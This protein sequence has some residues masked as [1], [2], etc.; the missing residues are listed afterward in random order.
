[1]KKKFSLI[2]LAL[3]LVLVLATGLVACDPETPTPDGDGNN[4]PAGPTTYTI[5][6]D[7]QDGSE[8]TTQQVIEGGTVVFP[9]LESNS[10]MTFRGWFKNADGTGAWLKT[11]TV[12]ESITL[13]ACWNQLMAK[14][15]FNY[16]YTGAP[17][18]VSEQRPLGKAIELPED[19]T[20][21]YWVFDGWYFDAEA[22]DAYDGTAVL[23][24]TTKLYAGWK[25]DPTHQHDFDTETVAPTC[26]EDGY[27]KHTCVCTTTY[28]DNIVP[29]IGHSFTFS[30]TDYMGMVYCNNGCNYAER[31]ESLR[32]YEDDFVYTFDSAKE[33][34]I[35]DRYQSMLDILANADRYDQALHSY[36]KTSEFYT[37][38]QEFE[39]IF[40][41]FY[42][43]LMYLIEQYQYAYVFYCVD[44]SVSNTSAY[45]KITEYRTDAVSDFYALYRLIYE[46]CFREYFFDM[47]EGGWTEEDIQMALN[48]SDSYGSEDYAEI[49][50]RLGEIEVEFREISDPSTGLQT[51]KLY[52][53]F[54]ELNN[55][56]ATLA[57]YDNYIEY[58]YENVYNREYSPEDTAVMRNYVK[59]HLVDVYSAIYQGYRSSNS[60]L[61][62]DADSKAIFNALSYDSIFDSKIVTDMVQ[63][64]F[65]KMNS[66][67][68][69]AG[70]TAI[71]F[72][73]HANELFKNGNYYTGQYEGAY[74]YWIG[75]Q[76]TSILY[77]GPGSYS[78]A[79]TFVH[80]FG[81]YYNNI[82]NPGISFSYD[83]DETHS[84]GNE[85]MFLAFLKD[86]YLSNVAI[87]Q[88]YNKIYFE[89]LFNIFN[90]IMLATAVDEF[91]YCVYTGKDLDGNDKTYGVRDYDKLFREIMKEY[92]IDGILVDYYWRYVV[93]EA[94][95]YYISYAM[96][97]LPCVELLTVANTD[98]FEAAQAKYFKFFTFTDDPDNVEIDEMGDKVVK[99]GYA[100]TL[101]YVGL[102]SIFEEGLY[103]TLKDY[104]VEETEN[105]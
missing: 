16:N 98:G 33:K 29:A 13:Y 84:Q 99:I 59:S 24:G 6:L 4:P 87:E 76:D 79:F 50:K 52:G 70:D 63:A 68:G 17:K 8:P 102:H 91:E 65:E 97:A 80:E 30:D 18:Q 58:A 44:D 37:Q 36:D 51:P 73:H 1:M 85:M 72:H 61:I 9:E 5:T 40:N 27:D 77:F 82:Y 47:N 28:N 10:Y 93:I 105:E 69:V 81:H 14:V 23:T 66:A 46:T 38:N 94:P 78:G 104:F 19:P 48:M 21:E 86:S 34:E 62:T 74:S 35:N 31:K 101:K 32:I 45:E 42:D 55:Q 15:T 22:T 7:L 41:A 43:D 100:D 56:I 20:R 26:T 88:I 90:T 3:L 96:S 103:T 75:A 67:A 95:C 54:V 89:N 92:G 71:D 64:Y 12:T 83:L 60:G 25:I 57:G 11:T 53:E 39:V 2:L 49:N